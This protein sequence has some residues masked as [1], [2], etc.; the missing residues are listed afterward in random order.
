MDR[1]DHGDIP[2][3]DYA[4]KGHVKATQTLTQML[5]AIPEFSLKPQ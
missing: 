1:W 2:L 3:I 5:Q 4:A